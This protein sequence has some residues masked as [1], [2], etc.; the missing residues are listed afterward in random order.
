[1]KIED[2]E[3]GDAVRYIPGHAKGNP[4][5]PDCENGIVSSKNDVNVFVRYFGKYGLRPTGQAT[6][7]GD[8]ILTGKAKKDPAA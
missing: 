2:F 6:S 4:S 3:P 1:M 8:L 5:H 7:P